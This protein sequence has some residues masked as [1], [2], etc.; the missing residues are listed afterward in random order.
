MRWFRPVM[1]T[2]W[3]RPKPK[4][5]KGN[6]FRLQM[7]RDPPLNLLAWAQIDEYLYQFKTEET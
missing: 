3:E 6:G 1:L 7:D 2:G 5:T 4:P